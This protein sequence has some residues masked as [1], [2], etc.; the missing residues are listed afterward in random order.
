[1]HELGLVYQ[2]VKTVDEVMAENNLTELDEIV[3]QV[4]EMSDVVPKFLE[5]AWQAT[6]PTTEYPDAKMTVEVMP[7]LIIV[8]GEIQV[9]AEITVLSIVPK[10]NGF[11]PVWN[12]EQRRMPDEKDVRQV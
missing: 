7:E 11:L 3:L 12:M 5:E 9:E 8:V 6:A 10:S 1:M 4:G 2:V